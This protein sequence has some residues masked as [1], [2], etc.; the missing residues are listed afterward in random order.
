[1]ARLHI[2][3]LMRDLT[4]G[5][6]QV[7]V[8]GRTVGEVIAALDAA[9]PGA[10]ARLCEGDALLPTLALWVDGRTARRGLAQPVQ[11]TSEIRFLPH[12]EGG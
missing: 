1:M 6:A 9:Y 12:I 3:P 7:E 11:A 8:P 4:D 10:R 2:P 5:Q